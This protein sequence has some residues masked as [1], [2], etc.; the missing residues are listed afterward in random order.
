M[1]M[2]VVGHADGFEKEGTAERGRR[3]GRLSLR[4]TD[5]QRFW[6]R[7]IVVGIVLR[8]IGSLV[9]NV[10]VDTHLHATYVMNF[11]QHG[12]FALD[13]GPNRNPW[14]PLASDPNGIGAEIGLR[15]I[16]WHGWLM[17]WILP[18]GRSGLV[19]HASGLTLSALLMIFAYRI[20]KRRF[21]DE[22]AIRL[23]AMVSIHPAFILGA[24]YVYQEELMALLML[25]ACDALLAGLEQRREGR[26]PTR[27]LICGAALA[28]FGSTKGTGAFLPVMVGVAALVWIVPFDMMPRWRAY[29]E[30]HWFAA[31]VVIV[32]LLGGTMMLDAWLNPSPGWSMSESIRR[33]WLLLP[34]LL[35]SSLIFAGLW[36]VFGLFL[37]PHLGTFRRAIGRGLPEGGLHLWVA[38]LIPMTVIIVLNAS[39]WAYEGSIYGMGLF[40]T[41][42][43]YATNGRY[44]SLLIIPAQWL[45]NT[46]P[47][48]EAPVSTPSGSKS[49]FI[50]LRSRR[51]RVVFVALLMLPLSSAAAIG[52][53]FTPDKSGED[54]SLVLG[55]EIEDE[56]EFLLV[57]RTYASMSRLYLLHMG[58]DSNGSRN[59][60]GHWRAV[61]T[62]WLDEIENCTVH[63]HQGDLAN[64]TLLVLAPEVEVEVGENWREVEMA[65]E[66]EVPEGWRILR[67]DA[68]LHDRCEV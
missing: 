37:W 22:A 42:A 67:S 44:M 43:A 16:A 6:R 39:F 28:L 3:G 62:P 53:T 41:M 20:T 57:T 38:L 56:E 54:I 11:I 23:T 65:E 61:E 47:E 24:S 1:L 36:G 59:I 45:V 30:K 19:L 15:Y 40:W 5:S 58:V 48:D 17:L 21:G 13:W 10:G 64:V 9:S 51:A 29:V 34:A 60:T 25:F 66:A 46:L 50:D 33:P 8:L 27:W 32:M 4:L 26:L 52:P 35:F 31:G 2:P 63:E 18:F 14:N 68:S 55:E 49:R 12:V 7:L